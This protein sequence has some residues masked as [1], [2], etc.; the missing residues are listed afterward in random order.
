MNGVGGKGKFIGVISKACITMGIRTE[1]CIIGILDI[2][3][4]DILLGNDITSKL[5]VNIDV[6]KGKCTYW[7]PLL[8]QQSVQFIGDNESNKINANVVMLEQPFESE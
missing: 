1:E 5:Q 8:G 6:A 7:Y 4:F 2:G 3:E